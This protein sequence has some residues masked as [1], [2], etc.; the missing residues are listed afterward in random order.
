M[1]RAERI[2]HR[3]PR[4]RCGVMASAGGRRRRGALWQN[5]ATPYAPNARSY[6][7]DLSIVLFDLVPRRTCGGQAEKGPT[8]WAEKG[9]IQDQEKG[10]KTIR[11][12]DPS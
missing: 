1:H 7:Y 10:G 9:P 5:A 4:L 12:R 8:L 2:E 3:R 6:V 11:K